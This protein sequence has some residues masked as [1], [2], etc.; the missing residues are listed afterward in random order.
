MLWER[1]FFEIIKEGRKPYLKRYGRRKEDAESR[2]EREKSL[3]K[4]DPDCGKMER[5]ESGKN[6]MVKRIKVY[7]GCLGAVRRR[8]T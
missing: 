4:K 6:N 5:L 3:N 2:V 7:G 1:T 8:R